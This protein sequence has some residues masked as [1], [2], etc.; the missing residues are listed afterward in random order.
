MI[1]FLLQALAFITNKLP[2][3]DW[4]PIPLCDVYYKHGLDI[5]NLVGHV[6]A[7]SVSTGSAAAIYGTMI[8]MQGQITSTGNENASVRGFVYSTTNANPTTSDSVASSSGSFGTGT[9]LTD[10]TGLTANTSYYVRAFATNSAG[11]GYGS[12]IQVTTLNQAPPTVITNTPAITSTTTATASG[13]IFAINGANATERGFV[14][15]TSPDPTKASNL[16]IVTQTGSFGTGTFTGSMTG[17]SPSTLYYVRAYA[18]NSFGTSYGGNQIFSTTLSTFTLAASMSVSGGG[19]GYA[20]LYN[21]TKNVA[22]AEMSTTSPVPTLVT[23]DY[24]VGD[25]NFD[26]QDEYEIRVRTNGVGTVNLYSAKLFIRLMDAGKVTTWN[27]VS[28]FGS[29]ALQAPAATTSQRWLYDA[30][31]YSNPEIFWEVTGQEDIAGVNDMGIYDVTTTDI[32]TTGT[33]LQETRIDIGSSTKIRQRVNRLS[34]T[35]GN[36]YMGIFNRSSGGARYQSGIIGVVSSGKVGTV[37]N[38]SIIELIDVARSSRS[39][40]SFTPLIWHTPFNPADVTSPSYSFEVIGRNTNTGTSYNVELL[41]VNPSGT[42][43]VASTMNIPANTGSSNTRRRTSSVTIPSDTIQLRVR[44]PQTAADKNIIVEGARLIITQTNADR[45]LVQIP[46]GGSLNEE[47][48]ETSWPMSAISSST[49]G[50]PAAVE[51]Q[52]TIWK[53]DDS[54]YDRYVGLGESPS[55]VL[56]SGNDPDLSV[57]T[58]YFNASDGGVSDPNNHW[59]DE[60]LAFDGVTSNYAQNSGALGD[61]SVNTGYIEGTGTNAPTTGGDISQVRARIFSYG[62]ITDV[63]VANLNVYHGSQLLGNVTKT[64]PGASWSQY[65]TL[66]APSGGWTWQKVNDLRAR[67]WASNMA[68]SGYL[69]VGR[70]EV[71]V[72][73]E[74]HTPVTESLTPSLPFTGTDP[75]GDDITYQIQISD[76]SSMNEFLDSS[77]MIIANVGGV[78]GDLTAI[79]R[80]QSFTTASSGDIHSLAVYLSRFGSPTDGVQAKIYTDN[81]GVPGTLLATSNNTIALADMPTSSLAGN[82]REANFTFDIGTTLSASTRYWFVIDRTGAASNTHYY[83]IEGSSVTDYGSENGIIWNGS[84]WNATGVLSLV[85]RMYMIPTQNLISAISGVDAGFSGSPDNTSP[86]TSG[87]Q[88]SYSQAVSEGTYYWRVR[89]KDPAGSNIW[90]EWSTIHSFNA[91]EAV[92]QGGYK[93]VHTGGAWTVKPVKYNIGGTWTQKPIKRHNG[94]SWVDSV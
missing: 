6:T 29:A 50:V 64:G 82:F 89:G 11:T 20:T 13:N 93:K 45:V 21:R 9:Y 92:G 31:V 42:E 37:K 34:L 76:S 47:N 80:G 22:L 71:E 91:Q 28:R 77:N 44:I 52:W 86:F 25:T 74:T 88:V 39:T 75:E 81:A 54:M 17:L 35:N 15:S 94:T 40:S 60:A 85:F 79:D 68:G 19:T 5:P 14:W 2:K 33:T 63:E 49:Y 58:Y 83:S 4:K 62:I 7:P 26:D 46:L 36:R 8:T 90:G 65:V 72:T 24:E 70:M 51:D 18:I 73:S 55:V 87:Q 27:R 78:T 16:G 69:A 53:R 12:V 48:D 84:S 10:L 41:A 32:G 66:N 57:D 3:T 61:G 56:N 43:T 67:V 1:K 59:T 23:R 38:Q 30:S